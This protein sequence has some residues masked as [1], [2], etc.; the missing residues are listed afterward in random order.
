MGWIITLGIIAILIFAIA[1]LRGRSNGSGIRSI[2]DNI[3]SIGNGIDAAGDSNKRTEAG[4]KRAKERTGIIE[5]HNKSVK[6]GI[7]S[8]KRI[9]ENA[10]KRSDN[11]GS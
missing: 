4:I 8:V 3:G 7:R 1:F 2:D 9:L 5:K 11:K 6:D 10:K